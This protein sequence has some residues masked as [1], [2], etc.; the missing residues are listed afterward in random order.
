M[1]GIPFGKVGCIITIG[2][3]SSFF[4]KKPIIMFGSAKKRVSYLKF[5]D[6][7]QW[8]GRCLLT[9]RMN[10]GADLHWIGA[11]LFIEDCGLFA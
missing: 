4:E 11:F 8:E 10:T 7:V 2:R 1:A 3:N 6:L 5:V 9:Y